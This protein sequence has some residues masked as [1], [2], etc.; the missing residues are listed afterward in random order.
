MKARKEFKDSTTQEL[1]VLKDSVFY[2]DVV[3]V[4]L[5]IKW[6]WLFQLQE[7]SCAIIIVVFKIRR[8]TS[9]YMYILFDTLSSMEVSF[10]LHQRQ[11]HSSCH[12]PCPIFLYFHFSSHFWLF[13]PVFMKE[14]LQMRVFD[15]LIRLLKGGGYTWVEVWGRVWGISSKGMGV[16][17]LGRKVNFRL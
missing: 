5:K 13:A 2:S 16:H 10:M 14:P 4:K 15:R 7:K 11:T 8:G 1:T 12:P 9:L 17:V 3:H 6:H